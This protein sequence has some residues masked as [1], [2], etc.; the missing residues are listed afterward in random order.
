MRCDLMPQVNVAPF[1]FLNLISQM[2]GIFYGFILLL[3]TNTCCIRYDK[4]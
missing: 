4:L 1:E 2:Q 3:F